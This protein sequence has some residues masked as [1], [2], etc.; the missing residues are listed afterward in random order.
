MERL[1]MSHDPADDF[2]HPSLPIGHLSAVTSSTASDPSAD[3][4]FSRAYRG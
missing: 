3:F 2:D 4:A 1:D